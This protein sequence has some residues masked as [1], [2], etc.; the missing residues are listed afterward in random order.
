MEAEGKLMKN[1]PA[2]FVVLWNL[3]DALFQL[4]SDGSEEAFAPDPS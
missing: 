1:I 4:A 2:F 3:H